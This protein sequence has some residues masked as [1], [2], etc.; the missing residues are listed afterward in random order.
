MLFFYNYADDPMIELL[1]KTVSNLDL[2]K[3]TK[4][5]FNIV[6][7]NN[8]A[9]LYEAGGILPIFI[10]VPRKDS[11]EVNSNASKDTQVLRK[12]LSKYKV[13]LRR[14][15][16]REGMSTH[17]ATFGAHCNRNKPGL[18]VKKAL[19]KNNNGE[20][21]IQLEQLFQRG[22]LLA[23]KYLPYGLLHSLKEAKEMCDDSICYV[24]PHANQ[25]IYSTIWSSIA[26]T[27][28]YMSPAH[29]DEDAFMSVLFVTN[30]S[31]TEEL[32][33]NSKYNMDQN[34]A[35]Y[36]CFPTVGVAVALRPGDVL[37][38]NP[39]YHHCA[40]QRCEYYKAEDVFLTSLYM[41][42]RQISK[43]DNRIPL[44]EKAIFYSNQFDV[45][46]SNKKSV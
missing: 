8:G 25:S 34:V 15:S 11:I 17:Y 40:S 24:D 31:K 36:F 41:K 14:G 20:D 7:N 10:L 39:I 23:R 28:N 12:V 33:E 26:T 37:L 43:S 44:S 21:E 22:N 35:F 16:K 1:R 32:Q 38:F 27:F 19:C 6:D 42:S 2:V 9:Q 45:K 29:I 5:V 30:V 18:S 46:Y 4:D 13:N 3:V